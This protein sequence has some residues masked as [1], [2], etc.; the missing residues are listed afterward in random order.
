MSTTNRLRKHWWRATDECWEDSENP[1]G[2]VGKNE[3]MG[4]QMR[5]R[6]QCCQLSPEN[7]M[8][9]ISRVILYSLGMGM[10]YSYGLRVTPCAFK[11]HVGA[12]KCDVND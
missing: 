6:G 10:G 8:I 11:T 3:R 7:M 2:I 4:L 12:E 9:I 1:E 5:N